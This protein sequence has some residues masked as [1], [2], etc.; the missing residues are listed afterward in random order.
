[1]IYESREFRLLLSLVLHLEIKFLSL[2]GF[3]AQRAGS[4]E[5]Y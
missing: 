2:L 5:D 1:M 4:G 3:A